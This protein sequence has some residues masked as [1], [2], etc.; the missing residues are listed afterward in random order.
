MGYVLQIAFR[1]N[2]YE[3]MSILPDIIKSFRRWCRNQW[4]EGGRDHVATIRIFSVEMVAIH[5]LCKYD[6]H[7]GYDVA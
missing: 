2:D 3:L 4:F 5:F 1:L 6:V 7:M